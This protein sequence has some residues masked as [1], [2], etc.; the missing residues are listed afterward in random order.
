MIGSKT[1]II[2][3]ILVLTSLS[4]AQHIKV[5]PRRC[6]APKAHWALKTDVPTFKYLQH[7]RSSEEQVFIKNIFRPAD[8]KCSELDT[9][10]LIHKYTW[11][12]VLWNMVP[13]MGRSTLIVEG[14]TSKV[15]T[16]KLGKS[17]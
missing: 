13:F 7:I 2:S 3:L 12:D 15:K 6:L 9:I 4:C 5:S 1:L 11:V 8:L 14:S 10:S 17:N 16:E